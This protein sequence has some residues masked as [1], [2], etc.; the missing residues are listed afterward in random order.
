MDCVQLDMKGI[1]DIADM[2]GE[3]SLARAACADDH[4]PS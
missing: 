2:P 4:D 3:S 1:E